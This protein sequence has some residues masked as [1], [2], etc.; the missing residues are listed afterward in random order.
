MMQMVDFIFCRVSCERLS[1]DHYS[2]FIFDIAYCQGP[3]FA[4]VACHAVSCFG[5]PSSF[6]DGSSFSDPVFQ[7]HFH[8][9]L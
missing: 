5:D 2:H 7:F 6:T 8:C 9:C 3:C 4:S 1:F